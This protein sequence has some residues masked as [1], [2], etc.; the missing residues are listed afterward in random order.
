MSLVAPPKICLFTDSWF[1]SSAGPAGST[2]H[3]PT[4][5]GVSPENDT[6]ALMP[7]IL[8]VAWLG[9]PHRTPWSR[10]HFLG[11]R[12]YGFGLCTWII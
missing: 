6:G 5:P 1:A 7:P 9:A 12:P 10:R 4:K 8:A 2:W 11:Q 3:S